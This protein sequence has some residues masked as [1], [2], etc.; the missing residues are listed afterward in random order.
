MTTPSAGKRPQFDKYAGKTDCPK[1]HGKGYY[2]YDHNHAKPC[3][4]CCEHLGGW[5][6]LDKKYYDRDGGKHACS[7]GCGA[8]R[9][10]QL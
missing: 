10:D 3:E 6:K 8:I 2:S 4:L 7:D 1:C 9:E 5:Y